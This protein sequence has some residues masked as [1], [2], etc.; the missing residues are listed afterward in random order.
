MSLKTKV[1]YILHCRMHLLHAESLRKP[2]NSKFSSKVVFMAPTFQYDLRSSLV[3][4]QCLWWLEAVFLRHVWILVDLSFSGS[5]CC[6][7]WFKVFGIHVSRLFCIRGYVIFRGFVL[8]IIEMAVGLTS[9]EYSLDVAMIRSF[10]HHVQS[11]M[12]NIDI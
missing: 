5:R 3:G 12:G 11:I 8:S 9:G 2:M 7:W 10:V 6:L 4:S 1:L